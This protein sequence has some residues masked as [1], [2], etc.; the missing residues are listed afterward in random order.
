M[1]LLT[2]LCIVEIIFAVY[3][4]RT[5]STQ[6]K[7]RCL[8]RLLTL[9]GFVI[10]FILS[11]RTWSFR[12]YAIAAGLILLV[13]INLFTYFRKR[14]TTYRLRRILLNA[15]AIIMLFAVA[16]VPVILFPQYKSLDTTGEYRVAVETR[17]YEDVK[18]IEGYNNLGEARKLRVDFYYPTNATGKFPLIVFSHGS[19]GT[20]SS[21]ESLFLELASHGYIVCT[22]DHTYQCLYTSIDGHTVLMD[23]GYMQEIMREDA[24]S[25]KLQS[26]QYYQKWMKLRTDDIQFILDTIIGTKKSNTTDTIYR[27]VDYS[28]IGVIGHSLG[29][30]AALGI[31]R[32]RK[33]VGA[34]IALESPFL[35]DI[36]GVKDGEFVFE[37]ANYPIPVLNVYTDSSWS[38]LS[39]WTQYL[40]NNRML[41]SSQSFVHNY[42]IPGSG[43]LSITDLALASPVLTRVLNGHKTSIDAHHC[44]RIINRITLEFFDHYLKGYPQIP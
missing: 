20:K 36:K 3:C 16:F 40:Q 41:L 44:L 9:A 31:G 25:D 1:L 35:C 39:E 42:H 29:G 32:M 28:K 13:A 6:A 33:D 19:F 12:Y 14:A 38:H 8:L 7:A 34:V 30:S 21:N 27:L 24:H 23:K 5:K 11:L 37:D 2:V 18:R 43:H 17:Q 10:L 4:I 26:S 22:I 15:L